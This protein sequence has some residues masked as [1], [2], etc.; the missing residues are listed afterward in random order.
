MKEAQ[1]S[2]SILSD[3]TDLD[4]DVNKVATVAA[5]LDFHSMNHELQF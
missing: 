5:A 3:L 4:F 2:Q 1:E